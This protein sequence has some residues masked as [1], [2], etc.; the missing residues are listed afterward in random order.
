MTGQEN[1]GTRKVV[2]LTKAAEALLVLDNVSY[3]V[4][5]CLAPYTRFDPTCGATGRTTAVVSQAA[6]KRRARNAGKARPGLCFRLLTEE[7]WRLIEPL[8]FGQRIAVA[9]L[10]GWTKFV[11]PKKA[12]AR[13]LRVTYGTVENI[14]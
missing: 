9:T 13:G 2:F 11:K 4:D 3:V 14:R 7:S 12:I 8:L 6:S 5:A 10:T 1:P